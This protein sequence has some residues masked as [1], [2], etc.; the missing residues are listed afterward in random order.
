[1]IDLGLLKYF[2][3]IEVEQFEKWIFICQNNYARYLL[4]IFRMDNCKPVPTPVA[5]GTKLNKDVERS[6]VNPTLFKR[7]VSILMYLIATR[8]DI[9]QGVS[10]ISIFMETPNDTHW[11]AWKKDSKIHN[12]K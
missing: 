1:M 8:L 11:S 10:F 2:F 7:L 9:M 3:G 5:T 12:M 6:D 4:K